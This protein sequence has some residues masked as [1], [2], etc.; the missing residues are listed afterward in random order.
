MAINPTNPRK[1]GNPVDPESAGNV[2]NPRSLSGQYSTILPNDLE[3]IR[4][5][6]EARGDVGTMQEIES[7]QSLRSRLGSFKKGGVTASQR[8]DGIAQRGKTKGRMC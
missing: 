4:L 1:A 7:E 3:K 5:K 2:S 6:A 8:A